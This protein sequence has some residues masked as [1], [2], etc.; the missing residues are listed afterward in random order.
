MKHLYASLRIKPGERA[1]AILFWQ[2]LRALKHWL[3]WRP[4]RMSI[5]CCPI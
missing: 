5:C 4:V 3:Y 2:L 1:Q